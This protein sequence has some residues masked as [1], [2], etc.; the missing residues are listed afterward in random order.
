L[1][2]LHTVTLLENPTG[3]RRRR[4][5]RL[6]LATAAKRCCRIAVVALFAMNRRL[7]EMAGLEEVLIADSADIVGASTLDRGFPAY[8][9]VDDVPD[10]VPRADAPDVGDA[11]VRAPGV[12][13]TWSRDSS[14]SSGFAAVE[15]NMLVSC[16]VGNVGPGAPLSPST[17]CWSPFHAQTRPTSATL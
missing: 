17:T 2:S 16:L 5:T 14:V 1:P 10:A 4:K 8:A 12:A 11:V 7:E 9:G 3:A 15:K 6:E 13:A